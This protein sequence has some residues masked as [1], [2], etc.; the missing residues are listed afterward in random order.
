MFLYILLFIHDK[1]NMYISFEFFLIISIFCI[2]L[3]L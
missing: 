1:Y 2:F 3:K